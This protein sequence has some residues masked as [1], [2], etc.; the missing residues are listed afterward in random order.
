MKL[1]GSGYGAGTQARLSGAVSRLNLPRHGCSPQMSVVATNLLRHRGAPRACLGTL[2]HGIAVSLLTLS[3]GLTFFAGEARA[4]ADYRNLDSGRPIAVEDA[5]PIEFH[6]FEVELGIPHFERERAGRWIVG[7]EPELK[8]GI[9]KDTQL[10]YSSE[11]VVSRD[12]GNTVFAARDQQVHLLYNFNHEGPILPAIAI[13]PELSVRSGGLGSQHEHGTL[14][15][16]ITKTLGEN[17]IHLN[18]SYTV[19]PT[20]LKGRGGELVNRFFYGAAYER[21][22]PLRFIVL[23]SD[24]YARKLIDNS[25]TQVIFDVGARMQLTPTWVLDGGLSSG[26]L[27]SSAGPDYGFTAGLSHSFSFRWL[28]P[29][30]P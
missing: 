28:Y 22:F 24:V 26:V 7:F 23:L 4:Q 12:S 17:R 29:T 19:G 30:R 9:L 27:R 21:T 20:A 18:G 5:Q 25:R 1:G 10:G 3:I 16:I 2:L 11:S 14:K 8:W 13:R 6:A 15:W